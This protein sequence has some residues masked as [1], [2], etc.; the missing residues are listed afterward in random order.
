MKHPHINHIFFDLDH[1][2]WDFDRNARE[3]L[4]ELFAAYELAKLGLEADI[5]IDV[6][7]ANN[8]ELWA[9]YHLGKISK[10]ELRA[11]RFKKTFLDLGLQPTQIPDRFEEDYV[12]LSPKKKNL[13]ESAEK[14]L[15][16]LQKRYQMHII[17]NGF[18]EAT[19]TKMEVSN[20]N[21][22]FRHI[23]ISEEVGVNKPDSRIFNH[24]LQLAQAQKHESIM[25]G[26]SLE[27]DIYGAQ[28]FG[29]EAI[30]FNPNKIEKPKEV[31]T[32]I[33]HLEELMHLF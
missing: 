9:K 27:A 10:D 12:N 14:V 21:P 17:S 20:L 8:H 19:T 25:I 33:H 28:Q 16:Y 22:F 7:T 6:Y 26:D 2:L 23:I 18:K 11:Q 13:F 4:H 30:F 3:T 29:M 5:F 1:T 24:A 32:Q 31:Q 15:G